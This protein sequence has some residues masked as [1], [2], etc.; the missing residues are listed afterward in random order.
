MF[1]GCEI[2]LSI[3][4]DFTLSNGH[5]RDFNSLH[6][7]NAQMNAYLP[8]IQNV[9]NILQFYNTDKMINLYGFGG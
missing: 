4:I 6:N 8:V 1:G 3:A 5:P 2:D 7:L 9:G